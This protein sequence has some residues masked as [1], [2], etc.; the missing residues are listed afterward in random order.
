MWYQQSRADLPPPAIQRS[1]MRNPV[2]ADFHR[3][4][5][6]DWLQLHQT[7]SGLLVLGI[8]K[9]PS[10]HQEQKLPRVRNAPFHWDRKTIV[11]ETILTRTLDSVF[12]HTAYDFFFSM[13]NFK[14]MKLF[15]SSTNKGNDLHRSNLLCRLPLPL[16]GK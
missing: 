3:S 10:L 5:V 8:V 11:A 1:H 7:C 6:A 4:P 13:H 14:I 15:S 2:F 9:I 12:Y 16:I